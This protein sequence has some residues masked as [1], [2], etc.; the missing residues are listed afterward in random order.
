M[1]DELLL[2]GAGGHARAC[3]DVVEAEGR[4]RIAGLVGRPGEACQP[5]LGYPGLG[6]DEDL[7][8]LV[9]RY[10]FALVAIGQVGAATRRVEAYQHL[11]DAGFGLP[12]IVSPRA[13][14]SPH[15]R[16][17]QGCIVMHGAIV[18]A[19]AS[20]GSNCIVNSLALVEHDA[21]IGDHCH[22][23][24]GAIVNGA[25]KVGEGS[26]VGS[27]AVLREG[28]SLGP[29]CTVGMGLALRHDLTAG[30]RYLGED[31]R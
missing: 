21:V 18:N 9:T 29:G 10:P 26:F 8:T 1:A 19:G 25:V 5:C 15:A 14:V 13:H 11:L 31:R 2:L 20:V 22:V 17:G 3:V 24:T 27:G 16:L 12:S 4:F 23:A 28:I 30:S 6:T 7:A